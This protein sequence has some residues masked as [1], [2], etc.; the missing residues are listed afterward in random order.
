MSGRG[1]V[2]IGPWL[3][4]GGVFTGDTE[5]LLLSERFFRLAIHI[6]LLLPWR[7]FVRK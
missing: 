5:T 6:I 3:L 1:W 7:I 2:W 4:N